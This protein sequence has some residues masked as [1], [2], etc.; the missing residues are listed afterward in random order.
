M[1]PTVFIVGESR[2]PLI[3]EYLNL[4]TIVVVAPDQ[5]TLTRWRHEQE[6]AAS[7][8]RP[9]EA[10]EPSTV[11]DLAGRRIVRD[12]EALPL[13]DLEYRVLSALLSPPGR[14]ISYRDLRSIG[15][16]EGPEISADIYSVRALVQRIRAKLQVAGADISIEA[17][18]GFGLRAAVQA[19]EN[20]AVR[21]VGP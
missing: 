17:V 21:L 11:V 20:P 7:P 12:G 15:W 19:K 5:G 10:G 3:P 1:V 6:A 8:E 2:L 9:G 4:G 18:K 13:S 14:A 16:G